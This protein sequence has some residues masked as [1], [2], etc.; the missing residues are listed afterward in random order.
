MFFL[1]PLWL[2]FDGLHQKIYGCIYLMQYVFWPLFWELYFNKNLLMHVFIKLITCLECCKI[3]KLHIY[4]SKNKSVSLPSLLGTY[5]LFPGVKLL[6]PNF[7]S[8]L[9]W[10]M[11]LHTFV[12]V[13]F[14]LFFVKQIVACVCIACV[15]YVFYLAVWLYLVLIS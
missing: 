10:S 13:F 3:Q 14:F 4:I 9:R 2:F 8:D 1:I 11:H 7:V 5:L 15:S 12:N 6:P